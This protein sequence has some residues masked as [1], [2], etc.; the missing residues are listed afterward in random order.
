MA[1]GH[2]DQL[3]VVCTSLS[4]DTKPNYLGL[5][6]GASSIF[7]LGLQCVLGFGDPLKVY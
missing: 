4:M 7:S 6:L 5:A 3:L 1:Y 2:R